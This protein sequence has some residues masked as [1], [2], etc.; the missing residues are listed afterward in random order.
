MKSYVFRV[1]VE[2]DEDRWFAYCPL[3][4][5]QG[6]A[7]WGDTREE[8]LRNLQEVLQMVVASMREH[9]EKIPESPID[10]VT[11]LPSPSVAVTI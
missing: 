8:A 6:G 7:T 9:G 1:V 3:L 11:V 4:Q 10:E 5:K 2:P